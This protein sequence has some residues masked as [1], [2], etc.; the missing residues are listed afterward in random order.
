[1]GTSQRHNPS[2][3]GDPNWGQSSQAITQTA[4]DV[5]ELNSLNSLGNLSNSQIK[6]IGILDKRIHRNVS[7]AVSRLV[8]ASGG[9]DSVISGKSNSFGKRGIVYG[10]GLYDVFRS[11]SEKGLS[12]WLES[13]GHDLRSYNTSEILDL[14][15]DYICEPGTTLD[16]TA[17][18]DALRLLFRK[19]ENE[20]LKLGISLEELLKEQP[21]MDRI[22]DYIDEFFGNYIYSHLSQNFTEKIEKEYGIKLTKQIKNEI[23]R[24]IIEDVKEGINGKKISEIDWKG[25][26]GQKFIENEFLTILKILTPDD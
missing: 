16:D 18:N 12:S 14:L 20:A 13:K 2:V 21:G 9:K 10:I 23:R 4:K 15:F 5:V 25:T 6:R 11:I 7:K 8:R 24:T 22:R 19:I 26:E 1:M 3:T 17:A